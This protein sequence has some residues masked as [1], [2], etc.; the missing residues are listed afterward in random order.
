MRQDVFLRLPVQHI[1]VEIR[2]IEGLTQSQAVFI[3]STLAGPVCAQLAIN[4]VARHMVNILMYI[5]DLICFYECH[6][7]PLSE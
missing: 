4:I 6:C 5:P 3:T 2:S 1:P 7:M